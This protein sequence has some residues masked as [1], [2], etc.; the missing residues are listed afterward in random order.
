MAN[1]NGNAGR[2]DMKW[3]GETARLDIIFTGFLAVVPPTSPELETTEALTQ[4]VREMWKAQG[5]NPW[6]A[7]V[8]RVM[9]FTVPIIRSNT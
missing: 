5:E 2:A 1:V 9:N 6:V 4:P 3:A 8:E 7:C